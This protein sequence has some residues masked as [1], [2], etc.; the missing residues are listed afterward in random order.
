MFGCNLFDAPDLAVYFRQLMGLGEHNAFEYVGHIEET[1]L[2]MKRC[3]DKG[4]KGHALTVFRRE[5]LDQEQVD[6]AALQRRYDTVYSDEH[7]I[8][9]PIFGRFAPSI[10]QR[11]GAALRAPDRPPTPSRSPHCL[12]AP[13]ADHRAVERRVAR[14]GVERAHE[15]STNQIAQRMTG[16][17]LSRFPPSDRN[18]YPRRSPCPWM[19]R[20]PIRFSPWW[21]S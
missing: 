8:P 18:G 17:A 13:V 16:E 4:L 5:V 1:R 2:A 19:S 3:L 6:W 20:C 11:V 15:D 12:R 7:A 9:T 21:R 14:G 10:D